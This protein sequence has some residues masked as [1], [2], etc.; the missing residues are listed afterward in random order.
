M[1]E[2]RCLQSVYNAYVYLPRSISYR[3]L[4]RF[5]H[6]LSK[7]LVVDLPFMSILL[8]ETVLAS[9]APKHDFIYQNS[10]EFDLRLSC[11][12]YFMGFQ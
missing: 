2:E 3:Q 8:S 6:K 5:L 11:S 9:R 12:R 4:R 1:A 7:S 10:F